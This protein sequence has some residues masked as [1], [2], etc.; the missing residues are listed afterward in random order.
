[1]EGMMEGSEKR[2]EKNFGLADAIAGQRER[3]AWPVWQQPSLAGGRDP[4]KPSHYTR[5]KI[6]PWDYVAANK[7]GYFEGSAIKYLTRWQYKNGVVD[8]KKAR[9]FI[10]KLIAVEEAKPLGRGAEPVPGD[11]AT[12]DE[13]R[14]AHRAW[15]MRDAGKQVGS[16]PAT[17]NAKD[18][19]DPAHS[20]K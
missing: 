17:D 3:P 9:A 20:P 6:E 13:Y 2:I 12:S 1:M 5:H 8:L 4:I 7:L 15:L 18:G 10:D 16:Q 14:S 11:F 19:G